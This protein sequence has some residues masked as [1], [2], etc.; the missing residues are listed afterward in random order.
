MKSA[1]P[2]AERKKMAN[3]PSRAPPERKATKLFTPMRVPLCL[4]LMHGF[5]KARWPAFRS[6]ENP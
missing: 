5:A 3:A 4:A 6:S 2:S 1:L